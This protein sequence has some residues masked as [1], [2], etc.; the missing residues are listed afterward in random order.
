VLIGGMVFPLFGAFHFWFPK[1]TGRMLSERIG[2][3]EFGLLFV[4]ANLA[5]FPMLLL[6]LQGMPRRVYTYLPESGWAALNFT[7]TVGAV[8]F[9]LGV[10]LFLVNVARS[11]RAGALAGA[12]PWGGET[13]EWATSSPPPPFN[14]AYVPVVEGRSPM[15]AQRGA[16]PVVTGLSETRREVLLTTLYDAEPDARHEQPRETVWPFVAALGI[17]AFFGVL[18]F[19]PWALVSGPVVLFI[20][21][22]GWAFPRRRRQLQE[23]ETEIV[24]V[25]R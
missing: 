20:G 6:A 21:L 1:I 23:T 14:F 5:F 7:S 22:L 17:F 15:W 3:W 12:D 13:L 4:G 2:R 9:A 19:T 16:L 24:E 11:L 18:I 25:P 8:I 10:A